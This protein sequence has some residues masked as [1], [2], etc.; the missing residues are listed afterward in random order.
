M[1]TE[2]QQTLSTVTGLLIELLADEGNDAPGADTCTG[3]SVLRNL[4]VD[5]LLLTR[6]IS[7]LEDRFG[8]EFDLEDLTPANFTTLGSVCDLVEHCRQLPTEATQDGRPSAVVA[9][10]PS[11]AAIG[12]GD[13]WW[14]KSLEAQL[15]FCTARLSM[16]QEHVQRALA[17][18]RSTQPRLDWGVFL[19]L[20]TRHRVLGLVARNFDRQCLGPLGTVR[21]STLRATYLYN[22]GRAQAWQ[23]ERRD[24]LA[25]F[26][27][28]GLSPVVRKGSYL[29]QYVYPDPAMRYME[30]MDLYVTA[31]E[32]EKLISTMRRLGYRQG[33]DSLDRRTVEPLDRETALFW[34]L[35]VTALPPFLRPTSD[36]YVDMFSV[37]LRRDLMEPASGKS[38]PAEDFRSRAKRVSLA[39]EYAWVP[40]DEDM[41]IDLGVHLYREAT[42]LSSIRSGKDL[43]LIR[44]IDLAQWYLRVQDTLDQDALI[45]RAETYEIAPE[46]YF[47]L[48]FGD[49][50]EPGVYDP[51]LLRRLRPADLRYLDAYGALDRQE[52]H[53]PDSFVDRFFDRHRGERV[54]TQS[55]LPRPRRHWTDDHAGA[56]AAGQK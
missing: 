26:A 34:Q 42:T 46:L 17:A 28:D 16:G 7:G 43:C 24:L 18:L 37:D 41:L 25:A 52:A 29:A 55:A 14:P 49:L 11:P 3:S 6:F 12:G 38:I 19:D 44:F 48:H 40:S 53:W 5:S 50:L 27:A 33:S 9:A 8:I 21:R 20:A 36:P 45:K 56:E 2:S 13:R 47:S 22:H 23:R 1:H 54:S 31:E 4:G 15:L 39:S 32:S 51:E 30:D 35:N 10:S